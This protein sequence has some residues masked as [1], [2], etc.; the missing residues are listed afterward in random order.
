MENCLVTKLK[1]VVNNPN[2][3]V[4]KTDIDDFTKAAILASGN[5]SMT[6]AQKWG[7]DT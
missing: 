5:D 3:P 1:A 4:L 7:L 2:L 6:E